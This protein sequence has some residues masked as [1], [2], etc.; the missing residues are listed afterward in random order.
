MPESNEISP[1]NGAIRR[2]ARPIGLILGHLVDN[3]L[4][5]P[6]KISPRLPILNHSRFGISS[7]FDWNTPETGNSTGRPAL[8]SPGTRTAL[9]SFE[10]RA[11]RASRIPGRFGRGRVR[12]AGRHPQVRGGCRSKWGRL[13]GSESLEPL[14]K[15][16]GSNLDR[17]FRTWLHAQPPGQAGQ[18]ER[19]GEQR[20]AIPGRRPGLDQRERQRPQ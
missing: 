2:I 4:I 3:K 16:P 13:P 14:A 15:E 8:P 7:R 6:R 20:V 10:K 17:R 9:G 19:R 18:Q 11:G 12:P 5:H 1:E